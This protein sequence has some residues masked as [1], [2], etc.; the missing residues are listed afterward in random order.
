M[1]SKSPINLLMNVFQNDSYD[2]HLM[3]MEILACIRNEDLEGL[4]NIIE[5]CQTSHLIDLSYEEGLFYIR[6]TQNNNADILDYLCQKD[7]NLAE[8]YAS[9]MLTF[10]LRENK[11]ECLKYIIR[12]LKP[13]YSILKH[14][15]YEHYF[16]ETIID[17]LNTPS[18][19]TANTFLDSSPNECETNLLGQE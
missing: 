12:N 9:E 7:Q 10:A 17:D 13:D 3:N 14:T 8:K 5:S 18:V 6:A 19:E 1:L 16:N 11:Q 4:K 2:E 15:T